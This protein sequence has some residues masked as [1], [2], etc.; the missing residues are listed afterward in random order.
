MIHLCYKIKTMEKNNNF[1]NNESGRIVGGLILV[2]AGAFLLL[3]NMGFFLPGWLFTWPI[4]LIL[5]GIYSG[6][7][8]NFRNNSWL[9]LI[10][11]GG[12]FLVSRFIPSLSLEPLFWP[13]VIIGLGVAFILRPRRSRWEDFKKDTDYNQWKSVPGSSFQEPA[14]DTP[15]NIDSND[16]LVARSV[17]SG[18]KRNIVTK[19]FQGGTVSCVFG[20][21]EFDLSQADFT[22]QVVLKLEMIFGGSKFILPSNW[23]VQNEIDGVF[24]GVDDKRKWHTDAGSNPAKIL[25]LRGSAVFG[26]IEITS[27]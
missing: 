15:S 9:I 12:F 1:S 20:G 26:G 3:R 11:V 13:L 6:F 5:V 19:N 16:F 14:G 22:G 7:K 17:F 8:H 2:A 27:Y 18:I 25:I 23:T 10:A 24:H 21:A 4:I